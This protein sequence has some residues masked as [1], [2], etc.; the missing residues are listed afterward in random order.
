MHPQISH[1]LLFRGNLLAR[2]PARAGQGRKGH[3]CFDFACMK[4]STQKEICRTPVFRATAFNFC[5]PQKPFLYFFVPLHRY[6][7]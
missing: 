7:S 2:N 1:A 6:F 5:P 3:K 4:F